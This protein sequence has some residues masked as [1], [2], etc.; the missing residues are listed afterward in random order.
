MCLSDYMS[1][2]QVRGAGS[3]VNGLYR[4]AGKL[5]DGCES[6][7][8]LS[9]RYL[10]IRYAMRSGTRYWYIIDAQSSVSSS[11][12]DY[13][14]VKCEDD[15]PPSNAQWSTEQCQGKD[16]PPTVQSAALLRFAPSPCK[17]A[18]NSLARHRVSNPLDLTRVVVMNFSGSDG[19]VT[20]G[21]ASDPEPTV[22]Y[23]PDHRLVAGGENPGFRLVP[24]ASLGTEPHSTFELTA[25]F[26]GQQQTLLPVNWDVIEELLQDVFK[27]LNKDPESCRVLFTQ[28]LDGPERLLE[29]DE[30]YSTPLMGWRKER[31]SLFQP[32]P[33]QLQFRDEFA[34]KIC[35]LLF[36]SFSVE[37][38]QCVPSESWAG[39][40]EV[41][42][43]LPDLLDVV[44]IN[45]HLAQ[46]IDIGP[47]LIRSESDPVPWIWRQ[48][49]ADGGH[50]R[51]LEDEGGVF[52]GLIY[53][54]FGPILVTVFQPRG[55]LTDVFEST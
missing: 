11:Q 15:Q 1:I 14:R 37:A 25:C 29:E 39:A 24:V 12:G 44:C 22:T 54:H 46:G 36:E 38:L 5:Y 42:Q 43:E 18:H 19:T 17:P 48:E 21:L 41:A 10:L 6:Y 45:E 40:V 32:F 20:A 13:Y 23:T 3:S 8:D 30:T 34:Q 55:R 16:P 27:E 4:S 28:L 53:E 31:A 52:S 35:Q 50:P 47:Y 26:P 49:D 9:E 51:P 33:G 7:R 2:Y